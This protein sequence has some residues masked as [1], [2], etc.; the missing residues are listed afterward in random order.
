M[1]KMKRLNVVPMAIGVI[2]AEL[3]EIR[4]TLDETFRT[5]SLKVRGNAEIGPVLSVCLYRVFRWLIARISRISVQC[6]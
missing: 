4:Q 5:V 6:R 2:R 1:A 3:L